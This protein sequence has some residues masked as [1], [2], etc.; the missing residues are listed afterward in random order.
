MP[1]QSQIL[2]DVSNT[3]SHPAITSL[4]IETFSKP[5]DLTPTF[6][7]FRSEYDW[8]VLATGPGHGIQLKNGRLIVPVWLSTGTG[9]H[10]HRPSAVSVIYSDDAGKTW[11]RGDIV[12]A[13]PHPVNPSETIVVELADGRVML[14][15]RHE[16]RTA[17][18]AKRFVPWQSATTGR[19]NGLSRYDEALPEPICMASIVRLSAQPAD[20]AQSPAV[21]QPA[22]RRQPGGA[23]QPHG[24]NEL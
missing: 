5:V 7:E 17:D 16:G 9:G 4:A 10:A 3:S 12:V 1:R 18:E 11:N 22:Q 20:A 8:Q 23:A 2:S 15:I 21:R 24:E 19:R 6:E 13:H 14:N